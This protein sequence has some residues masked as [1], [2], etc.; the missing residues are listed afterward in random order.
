MTR[1]MANKTYINTIIQ[2]VLFVCLH[3][4]HLCVLNVFCLD[5]FTIFYNIFPENFSVL[6]HFLH[7][8]MLYCIFRN[9]SWPE[10]G[11][12]FPPTL[13]T[14]QPSYITVLKAAI[15]SIATIGIIPTLCVKCSKRWIF[16]LIFANMPHYLS[17][18]PEL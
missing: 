11:N 13:L 16:Q 2:C 5:Y 7:L 8:E 15:Q 3:F 6:Y 12:I 4:V 9:T 10:T 1:R 18:R 14:M 17:F